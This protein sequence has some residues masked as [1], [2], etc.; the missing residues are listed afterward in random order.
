[1]RHSGEGLR[2]VQSGFLRHYALAVV[3]GLVIVVYITSR[4]W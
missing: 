4:A 3:L 2:K 1:V